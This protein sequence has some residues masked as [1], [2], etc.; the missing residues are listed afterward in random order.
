MTECDCCGSDNTARVSHKRGYKINSCKSC[1]IFFVSPQPTDEELNNI[2]S[3]SQGYFATAKTDLS[4][5]PGG[6][7]ERLHNIA[8]SHGVKPGKFLDI[9]CASGPLLYHMQRLG[10]CVTGNDLNEGA[11]KIARQHG[12]DVIHGTLEQCAFA[13]DS[14]D[15]IN[16]GDLIEHVK[17]PRKLMTEVFRVLRPGGVVVIL[18]PNAECGLAK[19]SM[20][21]SRLTG[22]P[23]VHSE[24]P[25]HLFD[26]SPKTLTRMLDDIG[27][28]TESITYRGGGTFPYL[29][30]ATGYF[31]NL[32]QDI[33]RS[34]SYRL[35]H[36]AVLAAP[37]LIFVSA[38]VFPLW[39]WGKISDR[40]QNSGRSMTVV[41]KKSTP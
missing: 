8:T 15:A 38:V 35:N 26:F 41:A 14:F 23:W 16:I 27:F 10:W 25:Y 17:S 18:T 13:D 28:N 40:I 11:L 33:K 3:A 39:L 29:V 36:K 4:K 9:G 31:D 21:F 7:A 2:Y 30:G 12:F 1:G 5:V 19:S 22:F 34:G 24:A 32:K 6:K 37:A 20:A